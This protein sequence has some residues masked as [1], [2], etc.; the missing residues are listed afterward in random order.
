VS[1]TIAC[2][3]CGGEAAL[4][5]ERTLLGR[6]AAGYYQCRACGLT[7]TT[8]P[9]WLDEAYAGAAIHPTDTGVLARNLA[10][11]DT[12]A[13][14]LAL[15]GVR[16]APCLDWGAGYGIFVRLMRD[17]G[18]AF[19]WLDP[20]AE[21]LLARGFEWRAGLGRPFAITAFE[22][23]EHLVRPRE[24]FAEIAALGAEVVIT[25]TEL[26]PG[27]APARDWPYLS[28]ES[29]QHVSFYRRDTLA[30]LGAACGYPVLH[31]GPF[32][33]LF[34]RRPVPAAT[35]AIATRLGRALFPIVRRARRSLTVADC[36]RLRAALRAGP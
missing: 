18:F 23:L 17:A 27:D 32:V 19:H 33:Q 28:V 14:W 4:L 12:V 26:H 6:H 21:N 1:A 5:F 10:L 7:Q 13:T 34:A 8:E 35:W 15:S 16:D 24:A 29:G 36:E 30:R 9:T 22:V 2:R 3:L 25:S 20:M 31:A 11:R